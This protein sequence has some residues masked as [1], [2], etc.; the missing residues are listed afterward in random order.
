MKQLWN[1]ANLSNQH[2]GLVL[3]NF[4]SVAAIDNSNIFPLCF[5]AVNF[6][7]FYPNLEPSPKVQFSFSSP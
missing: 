5:A 4:F 7:T 2:L 1:M 6:N 3:F